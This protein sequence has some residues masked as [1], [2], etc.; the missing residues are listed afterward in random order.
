MSNDIFQYQY[1]FHDGEKWMTVDNAVYPTILAAKR[2]GI[3]AGF[4]YVRV[5]K[6][7]S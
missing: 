2:A 3:D 5:I 7:K 1:Q 4:E 6:V